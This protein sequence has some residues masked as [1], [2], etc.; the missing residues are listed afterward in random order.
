MESTEGRSI[1]QLMHAPLGDFT[2]VRTDIARDLRSQGHDDL[3]KRIAALRKPSVVVWALNQA[4]QAAPADLETVRKA[5][6]SLRTSQEAV[7]TGDP[8]GA[9]RMQSALQEQRQSID[10]LSRRLGMVLSAAG[11]A[12]SDDTLRRV[13]E[14]LRTAS[15]GDDDTWSALRDGRLLAEPDAA[16]FST[17]DV[18]GMRAVTRDVRKQEKDARAK[19]LEDARAALVRAQDVERTAREQAEAAI[20]SR[21]QSRAALEEA[22]RVLAE[23]ESDRRR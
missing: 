19:Q 6:L 10:A 2:K 5:G 14:G 1:A 22:R 4:G 15:I 12:A 7:L 16:S 8:E 21:E 9:R 11:H 23:L 18:Q 17:M 13:S 3:A 20:R